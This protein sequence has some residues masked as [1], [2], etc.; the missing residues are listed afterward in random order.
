MAKR[1]KRGTRKCIY[2]YKCVKKNTV[3]RRLSRCKR[4][5]RQCVDKRCYQ[6]EF[7]L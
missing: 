6:S 7:K 1:C 5:Y 2:T 4:G 3:K